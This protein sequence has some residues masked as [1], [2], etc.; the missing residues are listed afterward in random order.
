MLQADPLAMAESATTRERLIKI[1]ARA[2]EHLARVRIQL[3]TT[4]ERD[5]VPWRRARHHR[6]RERQGRCTPPN[7]LA[8]A[9]LPKR[10]AWPV[11]GADH[12]VGSAAS[13]QRRRCK[14]GQEICML[15]YWR[16]IS[17]VKKWIVQ[18]AICTP[19]LGQRCLNARLHRAQK[20]G[21]GHQL[22]SNVPIMATWVCRQARRR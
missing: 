8:M 19:P 4:P 2:V 5:A 7:P 16:R 13:P 9:R 21:R 22:P 17:P 6:V 18:F 11:D 3:P 10:V 12:L 14:T 20:K 15:H 1:G